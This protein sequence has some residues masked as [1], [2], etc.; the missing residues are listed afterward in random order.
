MWLYIPTSVCSADTAASTSPSEQQFQALAASVTWRGKPRQPRFWFRAWPTVG[1]M[2][3]L[4]GLTCGASQADRSVAAWVESLEGSPAKTSALPADAPESTATEA[5][6]FLKSA[7]SFANWNPSSGCFSK[8]S[9]QPSLFQQEQL[10]LES[11]PRSGS[12]RS[13]RLYERP[14]WAHRTGETGSLCWPTAVVTDS[15]GARNETSGRAMGSKHHGGTTLNDAIIK[16]PTPRAEDSESCGNHPGATD[17]LTGATRQWITPRVANIKGS[18]KRL[19]EGA[20]ESVESQAIM[21]RTP[22]SSEDLADRRSD[23]AM[24]RELNRPNA[25]VSLG[26]QTRFWQTPATDSF[27][28][29]GGDRKDEM[30]LDQEAR[31][32]RTPQAQDPEWDRMSDDAM[33]RNAENPR[34]QVMLQSQAAMWLTPN[35]RDEKNPSTPE[36]GRT[37]RK[38][39]QGWTIDLNDTAAAWPMPK[40][41]DS[42]SAEGQAGMMRDSPDLNVIATHSFPPV[43]PTPPDGPTSLLSGPTLR[44]RLNPNFV[45]WLMGLCPG[46]TDSAPLE[47]GS[48]LSKVRLHLRSLL[49]D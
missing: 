18:A 10:Y 1:W 27:R 45:D 17:L 5:D 19:T 6:C 13:G 28:S 36:S 22:K 43:P 41:R 40:C 26:G 15:F 23:E 37:Q 3:R 21:W 49:G 46:W 11:L 2:K 24:A 4:S 30:G 38:I 25:Q 39:Q 33:A 12:M 47:T 29:L 9:R 20:N 16:W 14:M 7:D 35:A 34:T 8:T 42:K 31:L 44:R 32:W 48:Y